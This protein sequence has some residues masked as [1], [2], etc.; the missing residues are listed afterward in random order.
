MTS[1][2]FARADQPRNAAG[3][4]ASAYDVVVIAASIGGIQALTCVL[5]SLPANFPAAIV[6]VQH[7]SRTARSWLCELLHR[8]CSLPVIEVMDGDRIV[9]GQVFVAPL[10]QHV[11]ITPAR[12]LRLSGPDA[13]LVN[14]TRP[15]A[16]PLFTSAAESFGQRTIGI[17]LTGMLYDGAAGACRIHAAGGAIIVQD[18]PSSAS[19]SMP[20][21]A[22]QAGCVDFILPLDRIASALIALTAVPGAA[23]LLRATAVCQDETGARRY[24]PPLLELF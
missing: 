24:I 12:R 7:R 2:A 19:F 17:I 8:R 22:I 23:S 16:D 1:P 6:I 18:R 13:P 10:N 20:N 4:S 9:A 11:T 15:A 5:S 21:S 3:A 14:F